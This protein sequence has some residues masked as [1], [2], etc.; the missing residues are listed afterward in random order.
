MS[1]TT[2]NRSADHDLAERKS[3]LTKREMTE[4]ILGAKNAKG[5]TWPDVAKA[6]GLS[7]VYTTSACLGENVLSKEEAA[8]VGALL[9]SRP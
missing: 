5:I 9:R 8:K 7:E 3:P 2:K 4:A 1:S 6:V